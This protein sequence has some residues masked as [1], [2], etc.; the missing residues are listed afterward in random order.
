MHKAGGLTAIALALIVLPG[1]AKADA[2]TLFA[3]STTPNSVNLSWSTSSDIV[4]GYTIFRDGITI[5]STTATSGIAYADMNLTP[6]TVYNYNLGAITASG[7][8]MSATATVMTLATG[9]PATTTPEVGTTTPSTGTTTATSTV[10][11]PAIKIFGNEGPRL[12][13]LRSNAKIKVVVTGMD[14]KDIILSSVTLSGAKAEAFKGNRK[15][16]A[17]EFRAKNMTDLVKKNITSNVGPT[18]ITFKAKTVSGQNISF[19]AT[20][21][22]KN[23]TIWKK[24]TL[25]EAAIKKALE[26]K[27]RA[28]EIRKKALEA[29]KK[30]VQAKQ[31]AVKK[32]QEAVKKQQQKLQEAKKEKRARK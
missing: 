18:E 14:P 19:T 24:E 21:R 9:T 25:K 12:I 2:P 20:V 4:S 30:A 27:K 13:N 7:T 32:A 1:L 11:K 26:A 3:T 23:H 6:A 10:V 5:A 17:Y 28:L 16:V 15:E 8:L 22:I 29:Q 31:Q